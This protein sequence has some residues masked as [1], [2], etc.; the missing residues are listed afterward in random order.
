MKIPVRHIQEILK[1]PK[2]SGNFSIRDIRELLNGKNM[3]QELHRHDFYYLLVLEKGGGHHDIDFRPYA[4]SDQTV[5]L[6]YPG[7]VH[8]ISLD[9]ESTGYLL[10][11]RDE[12]YFPH[13]KLSR[14]LLYK[15]SR[16]N[17]YKLNTQIFKKLMTVLS[18]VFEEN[19]RRQDSYQEAIKANMDIFLIELVRYSC[20]P[21]ADTSLYIHGQLEKF[22]Q[23]LEDKF[24]SEKQ[25]SKYAELLNLSSYQLN[26]VTK[27]TL[28]KTASE[29]INDRIILEAKRYLLATSN[30]ISQTAYLLGF[31]DISYFIRFFKKHTSHSPETFRKNF[32]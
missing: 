29:M 19:N 9:T 1:E 24:A 17:H 4:I 2:L 10:Q 3:V 18:Y 12:F 14:Q 8:H 31:E 5:F 32:K 30:Q 11:F 21:S 6:M 15:A 13:D 27:A 23:I 7:Q 22:L 16:C 20:K 26:S 28:G 25:V